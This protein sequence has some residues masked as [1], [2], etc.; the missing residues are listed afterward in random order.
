MKKIAM[1]LVAASTFLLPMLAFA[2]DLKINIPNVKNDSGTIS[3]ALWNTAT[4]FPNDGAPVKV[5]MDKAKTGQNFL[6][7]KDLEPATYAISLIHDE[8]EN[9]E[10]DSNFLGIPTEGYGFSND[11]TGSF[12]PASFEDSA[13]QVEDKDLQIEISIIY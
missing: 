6:I 7:F 9:A 1:S 3:A 4:G 13:F 5:Q 11:A 12:G 10:L 2:A 8:N